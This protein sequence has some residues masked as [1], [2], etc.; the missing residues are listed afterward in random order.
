MDISKR[1]AVRVIAF[2]TAIISVLGIKAGLYRSRALDSEEALRYSYI[3]AVEDL[4]QS[5]DSINSTL[6]KELYAGTPLMHSKLSAQLMNYASNAKATLT[7]LPVEGMGLSNTYKFLSQ[8]GSFSQAMSEKLARGEKLTDKEYKSLKALHDYSQSMS[9]MMWELNDKVSTGEVLTIPDEEKK[10]AELIGDSKSWGDFENSFENYPKLI[11]DG[12]FSD[13]ILD[14]EPRLLKGL[15]EVDEDTAL[16]KCILT[17]G[18][19]I[20]DVPNVSEEYGKMPSYRFYDDNGGICC[21]VTKQGGLV[22]YFLK[23]RRVNSTDITNEQAIDYAEKFL[24][25]LGMI[26]MESTYYEVYDNVCTIN[27]A[28]TRENII[29]YTDLVK[30]QVDMSNGDIVGYDARGYIVNHTERKKG[31]NVISAKRAVKEVSPVLDVR[32]NRLC[33]IP[34]Q[35]GREVLCYEFY[36]L[37]DTGRKV[38]VY[39]NAKTAAEEQILM[40]T[41]NESGVLTI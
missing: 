20:K 15:K 22:S 28:A 16:Q 11:Y 2:S 30:V 31:E 38:L 9:D 12:P 7:Q 21:A 29:M 6:E 25:K 32:S 8:V 33:F 1:L 35:G 4:S 34:T 36:C 3:R 40:L 39:I 41:E 10:N 27:F 24:D 17:L 19:D 18:I 26:E 23:A 13:N 5:T 37:S 14:K